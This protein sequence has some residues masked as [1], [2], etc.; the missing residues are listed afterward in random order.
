MAPRSIGPAGR[1]LRYVSAVGP[2]PD[3]VR[4]ADVPT[5][6]AFRGE[7]RRFDDLLVLFADPESYERMDPDA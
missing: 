6:A 3:P 5:E 4:R 2:T 7:V 1:R